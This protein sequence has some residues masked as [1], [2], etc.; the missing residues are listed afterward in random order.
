M[1]LDTT[2]ANGPDGISAT[3]LKATAT[4]IANSVTILFNKS[5]KLGALPEEWKLSPV[6]PILKS[7]VKDSPKNYWP[8]SLLS[9]LSKLLERHVH[10]IILGHLQISLSPSTTAM[11]I[12][13]EKINSVCRGHQQTR[14]CT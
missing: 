11:G 4:S 14:C 12:S 3:M 2:K 8:I 13:F 5:I 9:K 10:K 7:C 1:L 6:N